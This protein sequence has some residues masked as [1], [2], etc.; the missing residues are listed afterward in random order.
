M[1]LEQKEIHMYE[2]IIHMPEDKEIPKAF[3]L[4]AGC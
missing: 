4:K 3:Y 1:V 2:D